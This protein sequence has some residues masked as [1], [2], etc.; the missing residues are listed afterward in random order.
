[1]SPATANLVAMFHPDRGGKGACTT[2]ADLQDYCLTPSMKRNAVRWIMAHQQWLV[3]SEG[4]G[5][6]AAKREAVLITIREG[7]A[8]LSHIDWQR[9]LR[10]HRIDRGRDGALLIAKNVPNPHD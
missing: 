10:D 3:Q 5:T 7:E 4:K 6:R 1:M 9:A 8:S 2:V